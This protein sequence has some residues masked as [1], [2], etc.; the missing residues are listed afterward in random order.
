[1]SAVRGAPSPRP[2]LTA[3]P[4]AVA[5]HRTTADLLS[6]FSCRLAYTQ[7]DEITL[8][9]AVP[10]VRGAPQSSLPQPPLSRPPMAPRHSTLIT[11]LFRRSPLLRLGAPRPAHSHLTRLFPAAME[12]RASSRT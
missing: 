5:M 2:A 12:R 9:F 11:E 1:M 7:S 6:Y 3:P 10:E 8:V 4:V